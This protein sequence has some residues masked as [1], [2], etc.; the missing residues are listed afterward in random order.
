MARPGGRHLLQRA[1]GSFRSCL[2]PSPQTDLDS[3]AARAIDADAVRADHQPDRRRLLDPA[4]HLLHYDRD[5]TRRL[6]SL[7]KSQ[8]SGTGPI[9]GRP[10]RRHD[11]AVDQTRRRCLSGRSLRPIGVGPTSGPVD[12]VTDGWALSAAVMARGSRAAGAA[13]LHHGG[14]ILDPS[15]PAVGRDPEPTHR[16]AGEGR[17]ADGYYLVGAVRRRAR[18]R[19][20]ALVCEAAAVGV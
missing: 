18:R 19:L 15:G 3:V 16:R 11:S 2:T 17:R 5:T 9:P 4:G 13:A 20:R 1:D 10:D 8:A 6:P 14:R 7:T 12:Q